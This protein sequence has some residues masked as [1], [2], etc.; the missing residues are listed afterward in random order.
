M[1]TNTRICLSQ[2]AMSRFD[3]D[4]HIPYEKM[5]ENL[6]IVRDRSAHSHSTLNLL[7]PPHLNPLDCRDL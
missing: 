3:T 2:V 4:R 5:S 6:K 7:T 1:L